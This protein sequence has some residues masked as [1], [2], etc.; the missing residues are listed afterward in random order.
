MDT[1]VNALGGR[2]Q[3]IRAVFRRSFKIGSSLTI[4]LG[5]STVSVSDR[6]AVARSTITMLPYQKTEKRSFP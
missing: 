5:I 1:F 2:L 3:H 4:T 6:Q